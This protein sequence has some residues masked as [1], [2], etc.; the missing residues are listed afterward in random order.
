MAT[1]KKL[2]DT[3]IQTD[4]GDKATTQRMREH[5]ADEKDEITAD[6][7]RNAKTTG[8]NTG[9]ENVLSEDEKEVEEKKLKD[10]T[11]NDIDTAWNILGS[12]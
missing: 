7:I 9:D 5:L 8:L 11:D 4:S 1:P 2:P 10:N 3:I 12:E 6:D